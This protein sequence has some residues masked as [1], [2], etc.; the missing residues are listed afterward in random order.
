[1]MSVPFPTM[2]RC[3]HILN[4]DPLLEGHVRHAATLAAA[5]QADVG[6]ILRHVDERDMPAVRGHGGITAEVIE[7]GTFG[8]GADIVPLN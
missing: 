6:G 8:I 1:M 4:L 3:I 5:F 7:A 2:M